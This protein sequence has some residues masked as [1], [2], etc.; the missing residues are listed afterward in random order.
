MQATP[1]VR[2]NFYQLR[3]ETLPILLLFSSLL[4]YA[5]TWLN[6][7]PI[8]GGRAP[9]SSWL[10]GGLLLGTALLAQAFKNRYSRFSIYLLLAGICLAVVCATITF[11]SPMT[12]ALV[13]LPVIFASVF[14][15]QPG[16]WLV[17]LGALLLVLAE[18]YRLA[19]LPL[20]VSE[21]TMLL[22][23]LLLVTLVA[24]L[25]GRNLNTTLAWFSEAYDSA[26]R[27]EQTARERQAELRRLLRALDE[28]T[29]HLARSNQRLKIERNQANSARRMKQ[30]L[31]QTISHELRTP[32]NIIVGFVDLMMQRPEYYG[33]PLSP[34]L[35][36]DLTI[37]YKNA[38][39]LQKLVSDVLDLARVEAA[40]M[41]LVPERIDPAEL[42]G[43]VV[44]TTRSL[45]ES[46]GLAF[47][48]EVEPRLPPLWGDPTRIRQ[49]L[50]NLINNAV[51]FTERGS[52]TVRALRA[53]DELLFAVQDTGVG[54]ARDDIPRLF[55][56][57][58]QLDGSTRRKH[59]GVGLGLA[60]SQR[61]V[62]LHN[63][64][65]WVESVPNRGSTF[66]FT[67]PLN[68]GPGRT[69]PRDTAE[70]TPVRDDTPADEPVLLGITTSAAGAALLARLHQPS[71]TLIAHNLEQARQVATSL[72]PDWIILDRASLPLPPERIQALAS[73]WAIPETTFIQCA[74]PANPSVFGGV[75][76]DGY[77]TKPI[78]QETLW[79]TLR[80]F[81][82]GVDHI[83]LIDDDRDFA[84]LLTRILENPL[85]RYRV[86]SATSG[87][88]GLA[89]FKHQPPDL[90]LLDL[91]L[92]DMHGAEVL[93]QIRG[94]AIGA[95]L[96][97]VV[98][99]GEDW[100]MQEDS[101][102]QSLTIT[103]G[104]PLSSVEVLHWLQRLVRST[105]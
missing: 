39:H 68:S 43:D 45:V 72:L 10:G 53:G 63:G 29:D 88:E 24:W 70:L 3:L 22:G 36:R 87:Q 25:S 65:I 80:P 19:T 57:F 27:N 82:E 54:I 34:L 26:Y 93:K 99:S 75:T 58:Q 97:V 66:S 85:R 37:I 104:R 13:L 79:G 41:A 49:V 69:A 17:A 28:T 33:T 44:D 73:E 81:G 14:L 15:R 51:R 76:F 59:G 5:W 52:V 77:L 1:N 64:Q 92:P 101:V 55:E 2:G 11:Q 35:Q 8:T 89:L 98:L 4:G 40:Q 6:V 50:Y 12:L 38:R 95:A 23:I 18:P 105:G 21:N 71:R 84:R 20:P 47:H 91:G 62:R 30:Q 42:V 31:A 78:S 56:E 74:L 86:T 100:L 103:H 83:L 7:W 90:I 94:S 46:Q 61:F 16:F 32:L 9:I 102:L 48:V 96:P 60:I 67:L